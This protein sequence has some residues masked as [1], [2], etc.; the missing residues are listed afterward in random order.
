M[1]L[2]EEDQETPELESTRIVV[3]QGDTALE[4]AFEVEAVLESLLVE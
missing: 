3:G 2:A 4:R 1:G